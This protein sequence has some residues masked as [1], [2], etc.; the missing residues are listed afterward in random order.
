MIEFFEFLNGCSAWR[1]FGYLVFICFMTLSILM[2]LSSIVRTI[3]V[4]K[5]P[6]EPKVESKKQQ[7]N[8]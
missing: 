1:A 5:T 6:E 2:T 4:G 8:G 7:L 3:V